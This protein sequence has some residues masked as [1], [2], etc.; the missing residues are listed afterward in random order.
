[1]V[2]AR[3]LRSRLCFPGTGHVS[4]T[5]GLVDVLVCVVVTVAVE[6]ATVKVVVVGVA[7]TVL[8]MVEA[9][10]LHS[11]VRRVKASYSVINSP[12]R[13][14]GSS[15]RNSCCCNRRGLSDSRSS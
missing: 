9:M 7:V 8:L 15:P 1:M 5:G 13:A 14:S 4:T 11:L 10:M 3:I 6:V 12:N 2:V